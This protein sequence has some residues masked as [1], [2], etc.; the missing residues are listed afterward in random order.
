METTD[1]GYAL[2]NLKDGKKL[3]RAGWNGKGM[4]IY[5]TELGPDYMPTFVMFTAQGM[6]QPG[7]LASQADM[8]AD[9]WTIVD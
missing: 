3:A 5:L 8:L 1:F 7:W 2:R 9:D 6:H 4:Y